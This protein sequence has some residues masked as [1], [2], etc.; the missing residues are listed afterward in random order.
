MIELTE[1]E[2]FIIWRQREGLSQEEVGLEL[3]CSQ[4]FVSQW[5]SGKRPLPRYAVGHMPH[6][7]NVT[8][9]EEL[10]IKMVRCNLNRAA[11]AKALKV[12]YYK[13][14]AWFRDEKVIPKEVWKEVD[15]MVDFWEKK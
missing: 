15:E 13:L 14:L 12:D 4:G 2:E 8:E 1:R 9:G 11:A 6:T 5:E 7:K 10:M 3:G